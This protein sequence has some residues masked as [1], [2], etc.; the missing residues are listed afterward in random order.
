MQMLHLCRAS[1]QQYL[2]E[3]SDPNRYRPDGCP[4]CQARGPLIAHGFYCRTLV[5]VAFDDTIRV[6]RYLCRLCKRTVSLLPEFALPY[7][8]F[9]L[10]MIS[11]FLVAR[12]LKGRNLREAAGAAGQPHMPYQRGQVWIRRFQKQAAALCTSLV[13]LTTVMAAADFLTRALHMLEVIGWI[14]AHRFLFAEMRM[15]LLG[16]PRFLIPHGCRVGFER[17]GNQIQ[18]SLGAILE[19]LLESRQLVLMEDRVSLPS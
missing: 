4:Q 15:H 17:S 18:R 14:A 11:L 8:R 1:I 3:I 12:L 6:R 2:Q 9:S 16:W 10:S 19:E 13:S 7:L 5:D